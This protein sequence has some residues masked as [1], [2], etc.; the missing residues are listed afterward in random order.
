MKS[1]TKS[2]S[3]VGLYFKPGRVRRYGLAMIGSAKGSRI[4]MS[5]RAA[6]FATAIIDY[7][8][9]DLIDRAG[10]LVVQQKKQRIMRK[11]VLDALC[12]P[13]A[14]NV[15]NQFFDTMC[16]PKMPEPL[17]KKS[18]KPQG[19]KP[20]KKKKKS[21]SAATGKPKGISK[22]T[23][24]SKKKTAASASKKKSSKKSGSQKSN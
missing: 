5:E 22:G 19:A 7:I 2:T 10:Q 13:A 9:R 21:A 3:S 1:G 8:A 14:D 4:R 20:K 23:K 15:M 24:T 16:M 11:Q 17:Y 18:G 6:V 12:D